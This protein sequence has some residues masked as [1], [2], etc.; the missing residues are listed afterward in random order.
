MDFA[1]APKGGK[2]RACCL[3]LPPEYGPVPQ[4]LLQVQR[5]GLL[6]VLP[7]WSLPGSPP[8]WPSLDTGRRSCGQDQGERWLVRVRDETKLV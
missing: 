3:M 6:Q 2:G 5:R 8:H 4:A 7:P 1:S